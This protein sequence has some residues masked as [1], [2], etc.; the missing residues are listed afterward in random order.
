MR[1]L[2]TYPIRIQIITDRFG[3]EGKAVSSV[4]LSVRLFH[5][6]F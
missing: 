4:G 2:L 6:I 5:F 1:T 3:R